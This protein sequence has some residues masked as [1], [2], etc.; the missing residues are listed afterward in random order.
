M[1]LA[2]V[3]VG[4][5]DQLVSAVAST[6]AQG[7]RAL[8]LRVWGGIDV[9]LLPDRGLD[10]GAAWYRGVPL[11]WIS[12]VGERGPLQAPR[13]LDWLSGFGG[14]LVTT[15]GLRNVGAPSD[16][17]GL[18]GLF[19]HQAAHDVV[20][21]RRGG[22]LQVSGRIAEADALR[23]HLEVQ[24]TLTVRIGEGVLTLVDVTRNLG[25]EPEPVPLLYHVNLG[26]PLW[27]A[28]SVLALDATATRP[29]DADAAAAEAWDAWPGVVEGAAERVYEHDVAPGDDGWAHAVVSSP[30][31][32][33]EV[34]VRWDAAGL[35][36]LWQWVHPAPGIAV[37]GIEPA[38]C[39]VLGR[40]HDLAEGRMPVLA[41][42]E[43]RTTRLE[44]N[45]RV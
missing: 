2:G 36:R 22:T 42:G 27:A 32:G 3:E 40:A 7:T 34:E 30:L 26:A 14:G 33:L 37:L 23:W 6:T 41:P 11:A 35:P 31:A 1:K 18:H 19:S 21:S 8:D 12:A 5:P 16:G 9:R 17:H 39:S 38:N 13:G 25:R 20:V 29:R 44:L 4:H 10:L 43:E 28:G 15:C 24:R 45:V